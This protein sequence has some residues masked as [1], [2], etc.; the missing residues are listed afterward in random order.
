MAR[1]LLLERFNPSYFV[2]GYPIWEN[3][4]GEQIF[5][6]SYDGTNYYLKEG[7][8][9]NSAG[10]IYAPYITIQETPVIIEGKDFYPERSL[11]SRYSIQEDEDDSAQEAEATFTC[12]SWTE[13]KL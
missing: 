2:D 8:D 3:K 10:Y 5:P 6:E 13:Q 12:D 9:V 11:G 7:Y 4:S 1:R